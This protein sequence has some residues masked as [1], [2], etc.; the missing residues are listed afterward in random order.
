MDIYILEPV[1]QELAKDVVL[2][3]KK[4]PSSEAIN[5]YIMSIGGDMLAGNAIVSA[6][7]SHKG[8]IVS[9]VI[10]VA[11]SMSAVISQVADKRYISPDASFNI[12]NGAMANV[13]G[14][15]TAEDHRVAIATLE[16]LDNLMVASLSR[17]GMNEE[18]LRKLM[19]LDVLLSA[20]EAVAL[21]FFDG[22]TEKVEA[23][24]SF[25]QKLNTMTKFGEFMAK[26]ETAATAL[27]LKPEASDEEKKTLVNELKDKI[28]AEVSQ[29]IENVPDESTT[30]ADILTAEMVSREEFELF[31]AEVMALLQPLIGAVEEVP[32]PEATE[33][34]IEETT[35]AKLDNVLKAIKSKTEI[36][37]AQQHFEQ[38]KSQP[39]DWS[40]YEAKKKKIQ[41]L[42]N[43]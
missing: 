22:Y 40:V 8:E 7:K 26:I 2:D 16:K 23:V 32:S 42:N 6:L 10:G 18:E 20:E 19:A 5:L 36:P 3:I 41:E 24:A 25:N 34:M 15:G 13:S 1:T 29:V 30:G 28:K 14:R 39:A 11:A 37:T 43:R 9:H 17:S 31:K 12:H 35:T 4:T 38:P 27:G 21:G 33:E